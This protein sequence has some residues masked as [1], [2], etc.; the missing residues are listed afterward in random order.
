[1]RKR[2]TQVKTTTLITRLLCVL[3]IAAMLVACGRKE[4]PTGAVPAAGKADGK[5]IFDSRCQFCHGPAGAGDTPMS[6]GYPNANLTDATW[7][8][9]GSVDEIAKSIGEG[10]PGTPMAGF[11][12]RLSPEEIR[13]VSEYVKSLGK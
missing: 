9:G 3:S 12:G 6:S 8:R 7:A 1:M 5:A 2:F 11:N 10:I 13:T 4:E